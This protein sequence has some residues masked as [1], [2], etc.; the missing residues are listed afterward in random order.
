MFSVDPEICLSASLGGEPSVVREAEKTVGGGYADHRQ[1]TRE[2]VECMCAGGHTFEAACGSAECVDVKQD[3][4]D[5]AKELWA[6][7]SQETNN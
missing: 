3:R 5:E 2:G 7:L 6:T 1:R 4:Y